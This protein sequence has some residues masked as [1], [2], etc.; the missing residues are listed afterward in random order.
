MRSLFDDTKNPVFRL[1]CQIVNE[2]G[3]GA[4]F[5]RRDILNRIFELPEFIYLE[6]PESLREEN[7]VDTLFTFSRDGFAVVPTVKNFS[8]PMSDT[9]LCWLSAIFTADEN[10][11]L[12]PTPLREKLSARLKNFPPLYDETFW[13]KIR[14]GKPSEPA[15]KIFSDKLS[16]AVE[17]LRL[18]K[19]IA[20]GDKPFTP[21]R[22]EYDLFADKFF[23]I[24]LR[25]E[26]QA[27][28]KISVDTMSAPRLTSESAAPDAEELLEKFY[29]EHVAEVTIKIRNARNAV[30]RC[31]ALLSSFDKKARLQNDGTYFL[32]VRYCTFDEAEVF[33]KIFSL[34]ATVEV[35]AP[36]NFRERIIRKF[37]AIKA[38]YD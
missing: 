33:E 26:T 4:K 36:K 22:L 5:T 32:T 37:S 28:E 6:A 25:E 20:C 29:A 21:C 19:K 30:E 31:F 13:R 1:L 15:G 10:S 3:A 12:L 38:L 18:R 2:I 8:L 9:E 35:V 34:G 23:L 11:F 24:V 14:P 17:A 16:V 27:V 7:L